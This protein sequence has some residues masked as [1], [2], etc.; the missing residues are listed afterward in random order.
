MMRDFTYVDD[1][2]NAVLQVAE[3]PSAANV[4]SGSDVPAPATSSAPFRVC[5]IGGSRA[6]PAAN[7]VRALER[8]LEKKARRNIPMQPAYMLT[9]EAVMS[10]LARD[11]GS[12]RTR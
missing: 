9:T 10:D 2:V 3:R 5:N 8:F 1:A 11:R 6:E 12:G 4:G 7:P